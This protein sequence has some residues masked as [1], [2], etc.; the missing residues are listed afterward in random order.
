M[1]LY[2]LVTAVPALYHVWRALRTRRLLEPAQ[3]KRFW[4]RLLLATPLA[5]L[6]TCLL[7]WLVVEVVNNFLP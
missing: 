2:L 7:A 6:Q 5:L 1:G 3:R 4:G